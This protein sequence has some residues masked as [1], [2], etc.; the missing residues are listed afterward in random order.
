MGGMGSERHWYWG[1]KNSTGDYRSIYVRTEPS[2]VLLTYRHRRGG[3]DW[4]DASYP[5]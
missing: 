1:A 4:Q 3:E 5:V 2:R